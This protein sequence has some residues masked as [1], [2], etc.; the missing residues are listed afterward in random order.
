MKLPEKVRNA[1][2]NSM[3]TNKVSG[4]RLLGAFESSGLYLE[5]LAENGSAWRVSR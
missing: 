3:F 1:M 4:V 2:L 5:M